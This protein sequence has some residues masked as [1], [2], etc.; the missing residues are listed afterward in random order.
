MRMRSSVTIALGALALS[1]VLP[2]TASADTENFNYYIPGASDSA[3]VRIE[4]PDV[5]TC[6]E[7][8]ALEE[9]QF[10]QRLHNATGALAIVFEGANCQGEAFEL[11][12]GEE[13]AD[14]EVPAMSVLF[15]MPEGADGAQPAQP[16]EP[17]EEGEEGQEEQQQIMP[18]DES[19]ESGEAEGA[20]EDGYL[21]EEPA[22]GE[23][24]ARAHTA[25]HGFGDFTEDFLHA[26]G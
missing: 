3:A 7:L 9:G 22:D 1:V 11:A 10:P 23:R 2:G 12:P 26:W 16:A 15:V 6:Y 25:D 24:A 8:E 17:G 13:R 4:N 20:D 19:G 21:D 18:V 14:E 5:D